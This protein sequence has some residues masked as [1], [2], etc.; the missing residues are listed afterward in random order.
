M[1]ENEAVVWLRKL[2]E[3]AYEM[4]SMCMKTDRSV[5]P[6]NNFKNTIFTKTKI[7]YKTHYIS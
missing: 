4:W 1:E 6:K 7:S 2:Y 3:H 5:I